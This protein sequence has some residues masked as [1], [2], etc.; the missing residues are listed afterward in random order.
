MKKIIEQ[1]E[2]LYG[3]WRREK[4]YL[5]NCVLS[6]YSDKIYLNVLFI[7]SEYKKNISFFNQ[8]KIT[9]SS[10]LQ[11]FYKNYNGITLFSHSFV[12]YGYVETLEPGYTP[13]NLATQNMRIRVKNKAWDDNYVSI[14]KYG[15]YDF[16]L[17]RSDRS[18]K[19]YVID[20]FTTK[21]KTTFSS[22]D[23]LLD[24]CVKKISTLYDQNG[25]K[26]TAP[27]NSKIWADN[28]CVN[29]EIF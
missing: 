15:K 7:N 2:D 17:K 28:M 4:D 20:R 23:Q 10:E 29:E 13:L 12:I 5:Y 14:G 16:C 22:F 24:Y 26:K 6:K 27:N 3:P 21:I 19:I 18:E 1:L 11:S 8:N 25:L 9:L